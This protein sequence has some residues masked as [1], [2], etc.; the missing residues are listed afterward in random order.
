MLTLSRDY[1]EMKALFFFT[2]IICPSIIKGQDST[3]VLG[4]YSSA[5]IS[6][7]GL[8]CAKI[9]MDAIRGGGNAVDAAIA[10]L[11]CNGL[12][13]PH[14]CG[15]GGSMIMTLYKADTGEAKS[16]VARSMAPWYANENMFEG[17]R[18]CKV[19]GQGWAQGGMVG[20]TPIVNFEV[21]PHHNNFK[22]WEVTP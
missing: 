12:Y 3:G 19:Q 18:L 7:D 13:S 20:G 11:F 5:G 17:K 14:L 2:F 15:I 8:P 9:G 16:L 22:W 10:A 21:T 1:A 4:N 6:I